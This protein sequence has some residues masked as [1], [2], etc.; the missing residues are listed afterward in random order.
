MTASSLVS[1][2][3]PQ[4]ARG[5]RSRLDYAL[6]SLLIL[7]WLLLA[8]DSS[9]LFTP[10][11]GCDAWVYFGYYHNLPGYIQTF[12]GLYYTTRLSVT[13]PGWLAY[14]SLPPMAANA[15]LH[16]GLYYIGV[17][18]LYLILK[19]TVSGR[20]AFLGALTLGCHSMFLG[21]VG[22]DY[23]DGYGITYL[24]LSMF[25]MTRATASVRRRWYLAAAGTAALAVF[26]A[27]LLYLVLVPF[28]ALCFLAIDLRNW[29]D[30]RAEDGQMRPGWAASIRWLALLRAVGWLAVGGIGLML[31][32]GVFN[33]ACGGRFWFLLPSLTYAYHFTGNLEKANVWRAPIHEWLPKA[34][35]L[36]LP[37]LSSLLALVYLACKWWRPGK[38]A[39]R[40]SAFYQC[41]LLLL[42]TTFT[43]M[44]VAGFNQLQFFFATN[45]LLPAVFLALG[46]Q[47]GSLTE[48]LTGGQFLYFAA[49]AALISL[50]ALPAVRLG[51]GQ[52]TAVG[53][54]LFIVLVSLAAGACWVWRVASTVRLAALILVLASVCNLLA[55]SGGHL[56]TLNSLAAERPGL[57]A[58]NSRV[59]LQMLEKSLSAVCAQEQSGNV[60]F[61][62][63]QRELL[64]P[65][66]RTCAST[67]LF[68]Y[69]L[70]NW[71]FPSLPE[72]PWTLGKSFQ[73]G[74]K[75]AILSN[76]P[77]ALARADST[78]RAQHGLGAR[79]LGQQPIGEL[80]HQ[81]T[82]TLIQT[83]IPPGSEV[84]LAVHFQ[85]EE[86][87][88]S[89][90]PQADGEGPLPLPMERWK[91]ANGGPGFIMTST[92]GGWQVT[93]S[94]VRWDY[95]TKYAP[96]VIPSDG[97]YRVEIIYELQ[98]GEIDFGA[99]SGDQSHWVKQSGKA[100]R[101]ETQGLLKKSFTVS[102]KS[103]ETI[104]PLIANNH[105]EGA[106]PSRFFLKEMRA[107]LKKQPLQDKAAVRVETAGATASPPEKAAA[108]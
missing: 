104:W 26:I 9:W 98:Q 44:Q 47:L 65:I 69:R 43:A 21:A 32:L 68:M 4:A 48:R 8:I 49:A 71:D 6:V 40:M 83:T 35:W 7:P 54:V 1:I 77:D 81:F 107:Y 91:P 108:E 79:L 46:S 88:G 39:G 20:A 58:P 76:R 84:P 34:Y 56:A 2:S 94:S 97:A 57:L 41:H 11:G 80:P 22:W 101:T 74:V 105:P 96:L 45:M 59:N 50:A 38:I 90:T 66:Y 85:K 60:W 95:A 24:L 70:I 99:L 25:L 18:S 19:A 37:V 55:W 31:A 75:I 73:E 28:L 36:L 61:W 15:V 12:D 86:G 106:V 62:Y 30:P 102:L 89:L 14:S 92:A 93:T 78:L 52:L 100:I 10:P 103:G 5:L 82:L 3:Q 17:L 72:I 64:G 27:N 53:G 87:A 51:G 23:T 33:Y 63:D 16:L 42:A 67:H 29:Y 13:I